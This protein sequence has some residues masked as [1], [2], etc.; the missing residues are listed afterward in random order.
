MTRSVILNQDH[1]NPDGMRFAN[2]N[3]PKNARITSAF[4]TFTSR[5]DLSATSVNTRIIGDK[6]ADAAGFST[7]ADY[8][9]R[10]GT[11]I[12]GHDDTK[13]TT[14]RIT[15]D[16]I[17][18]W[19]TNHQYRSPDISTI[20]QEII[21]QPGWTNG[22]H[23]AVFWDDHEGRSSPV[24]WAGREALSYLSAN[25]K[26][27]KLHI[28]Y[29]SP[30]ATYY[31]PS[32]GYGYGYSGP[33]TLQYLVTINTTGMV[34]GNYNAQ[35]SINV[36][37]AIN[38]SITRFLSDNYSFSLIAAP[39]DGGGGGSGGGGG[40]FG[41][42]GFGGIAITYPVNLDQLSGDAIT[43]DTNGITTGIARLMSTDMNIVIN[44]PKGTKLQNTR[45]ERLTLISAVTAPVVPPPPPGNIIISCIEFLPGGANF[46][47]GISIS[48]KYNPPVLSAAVSPNLLYILP[49]GMELTGRNYRGLSTLKIK[50]S[51][52]TFYILLNFLYAAFKQLPQQ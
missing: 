37:A 29:T 10:R 7:F 33:T 9:S 39:S 43:L 48:F 36:P 11:A 25:D 49:G 44:I 45:G 46:N 14:A 35:T 52:R 50:P 12:G 5:M 2:A 20:I 31:Q 16:N 40:W 22:N 21:S 17:E 28:E 32:W 34:P 26:S 18:P 38:S 8:Q 47:P 30:G 19:L 6:E 15:W 42:G 1:R 51:L 24:R 4:L 23:L 13:L 41:G 27:V 3:I